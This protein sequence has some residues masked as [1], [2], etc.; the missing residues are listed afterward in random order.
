M[1]RDFRGQ[2][3]SLAGCRGVSHAPPATRWLAGVAVV[4]WVGCATAG[5]Q[6]SRWVYR[7][8][9]GRLGRFDW[10]LG[11]QRVETDNQQPNAA[12]AQDAGL[13]SIG[14]SVG[15][16]TR[17]RLVV[18]AEQSQ[19]GT[20]GQTAFGRPDLDAHH[21]RT[22]LVSGLQLSH[23]R[24]GIAHQIRAGWSR[25]DQLSLN[26]EDSGGFVPSYGNRAPRYPIVVVRGR[27]SERRTSQWRPASH[28]RART[29]S[30][31]ESSPP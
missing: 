4:L 12:F 25:T 13:A 1:Q 28:A 18:R 16:A 27:L 7:G 6:E 3:V 9:S 26:P 31:E 17:A 21:R 11:A 23:V 30:L 15:E 24:E 22:S 29:R 19:A 20:P 5:A 2:R 8:S 14:A 10:N